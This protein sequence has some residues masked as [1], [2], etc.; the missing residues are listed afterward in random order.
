M[1]WIINHPVDAFQLAWSIALKH[2]A[3]F[4]LATVVL[5]VLLTGILKWRK[6]RVVL[7]SIALM[8]FGCVAICVHPS[9]W[10]PGF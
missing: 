4:C 5:A 3:I 7:S 9:G 1:N 2:C 10:K 8:F 6:K